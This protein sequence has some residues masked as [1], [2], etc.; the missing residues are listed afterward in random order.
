M[1]SRPSRSGPGPFDCANG[2]K[3][4][5]TAAPPAPFPSPTGQP[6]GSLHVAAPN[7]PP[8]QLCNCTPPTVAVLA[9]TVIVVTS[10]RSTPAKFPL[11]VATVHP[12]A[13]LL[14]AAQRSRRSA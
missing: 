9:P 1:R 13:G 5:I 12:V 4:S 6:P 2:R 14:I 8:T 10:R 11:T 3:V 7:A